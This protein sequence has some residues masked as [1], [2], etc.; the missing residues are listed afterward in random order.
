M[1]LTIQLWD[2][3]HLLK[4]KD[5]ILSTRFNKNKWR[6]SVALAY[7]FCSTGKVLRDQVSI[8]TKRSL[9]SS[10]TNYLISMRKSGRTKNLNP[11]KA[12]ASQRS[13]SRVLLDL[14]VSRDL[15]WKKANCKTLNFNCSSAESNRKNK[16]YCLEVKLQGTTNLLHLCPGSNKFAN[17][18]CLVFRLRLKERM[19]YW[20]WVTKGKARGKTGLNP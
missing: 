19:V 18:I 12:L 17:R 10:A 4:L 9:N 2:A 11:G 8:L 20:V 15:N 3:A 1:I 6:K 5:G 13:F 14:K 16:T 7:K